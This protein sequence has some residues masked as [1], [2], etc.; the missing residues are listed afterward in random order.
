MVRM[1]KAKAEALGR[2]CE[3]TDFL[4]QFDFIFERSDGLS[5]TLHP[6]HDAKKKTVPVNVKTENEEPAPAP[7]G[8]IF[9]PTGQGHFNEA[10]TGIRPSTSN[11]EGMLVSP[12][13]R[14]PINLLA[15]ADIRSGGRPQ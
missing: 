13:W 14:A 6:K 15:V 5:F 9:Q 10:I 1:E 4:N 7:T 8:D 12:Q 3:L 11:S 2:Q